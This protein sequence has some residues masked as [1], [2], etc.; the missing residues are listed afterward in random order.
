MNYRSLGGTGLTVS[1]VGFGTWGIGGATKGAVSYGPTDDAQ[2]RRALRRA[3]DLGITF[4][5]TADLYGY[6]H[7]ETLLG[8]TF[9]GMRDKVVIASKVGF[10]DQSG[11]QDFSP[12]HIRKSIDQT[13]RRLQSDYV[14][15]Y[16]LHDPGIEWLDAHPDVCDTLS[17][18]QKEGKIRARGISLRAPEDG[19]SAIEKLGFQSIQVNFNMVDQRP[20]DSGDGGD[21]GLL[22]LC[23]SRNV[24]VIG[25]TP[26]CFGFLTGKYSASTGFHAQDHRSRW[27]PEQIDLWVG[28]FRLFRESGSFDGQTDTQIALRFCLSYPEISTTI[29]GMLSEREVEENV[30][31]GFAGALPDADRKQIETIYRKQRFYLG[32]ASSLK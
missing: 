2:S 26:L 27:S 30:D 1:E 5:D 4:Y 15:L 13:L 24:G 19:P 11:G 6:G 12:D 25:R 20:I 32:A 21:G 10:L 14:D 31:A 8:E 17:V 28:A 7:S 3:L 16:Q 22:D 23:R 9:K 18:L 29:P